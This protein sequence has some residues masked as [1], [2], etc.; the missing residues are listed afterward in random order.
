MKPSKPIT[1][2]K[3]VMQAFEEAFSSD[4]VLSVTKYPLDFSVDAEGRY[5]DEYVNLIFLGWVVANNHCDA[6]YEQQHIAGVY[7]PSAI[8][9]TLDTLND[10]HSFKDY[11]MEYS[12]RS[13]RNKVLKNVWLAAQT[14]LEFAMSGAMR[15]DS[16]T[17]YNIYISSSGKVVDC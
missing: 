17:E 15:Y 12:I 3:T 6:E 7:I 2:V 16:C 11:R 10:K 9:D 5:I 13:I 4:A 1:Q 8:K 14:S